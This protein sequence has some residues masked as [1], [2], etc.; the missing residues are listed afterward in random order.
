MPCWYAAVLLNE[1]HLVNFFYRGDA[2][3]NFCQ[4]AF[5]QSD[6]AFFASDAL[7]LRSR[8]AI[9]D[10][11]A[12]AVGQV[13][14][15]ANCRAAV[16][17]GA[18]AFQA[19]GALGKR[20][21]PPHSRIE[22]GFFQFLGRISLGLLAIWTDHANEPLRH[23]AVESGDKVVRLDAHIDEAADDVG[24]V[25][26]MDSGEN[27]VAGEGRLD[28]DLRGFLVANFADHDLVGVVT[29]DGAQASREGEAL[30][31]VHR[32]LR[33]TAELILHRIFDG[34]DFVFVGLDLVDGRIERGGLSGTCGTR[35][36]DHAIRFADIAPETA[37]FFP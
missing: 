9:H 26:G 8:P 21:V 22:A 20:D 36:Q 16:I 28:G 6:H 24:H 34:D 27:E 30:L 4:P 33:D 12:D 37:G 7:D 17:T 15:F 2:R 14:Q 3:A 13:E 18:R 35:N 1:S 11:F 32:N 25:V 29:Q 5:A 31:L 23:D 10:H 19:P